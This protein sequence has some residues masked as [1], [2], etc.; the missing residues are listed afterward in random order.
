MIGSPWLTVPEAAAYAK[1]GQSTIR[2]AIA[3][4][5]L[6]AGRVGEGPRGDARIHRDELDTW[7]RRPRGV[8]RMSA[9]DALAQRIG[10]GRRR[11]A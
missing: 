10:P 9:T 5:A 7:L 8:R 3:N 2:R 11:T 1:A 4:G 6:P